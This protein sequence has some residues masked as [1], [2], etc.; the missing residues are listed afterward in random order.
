MAR[1]ETLGRTDN[2]K[3]AM[4]ITQRDGHGPDNVILLFKL[5]D[6]FPK[7]WRWPCRCEKSRAATGLFLLSGH[8]QSSPPDTV[9]E[10]S[11]RLL[12]HVLY[13]SST[14]TLNATRRRQ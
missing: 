14:K 1:K 6:T 3:T 12:A 9:L 11:A 13:P 5:F 4:G 7:R 8:Q 2:A 10:T